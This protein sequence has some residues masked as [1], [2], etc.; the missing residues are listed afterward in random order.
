MEYSRSVSAGESSRVS[1]PRCVKIYGRFHSITYIV[2]LAGQFLWV[3]GA[4][5]E[6]ALK[7]S[8]SADGWI[9]LCQPRA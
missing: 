4:M 1:T 5:V 3:H 6:D 8:L 9:G 7:G 2:D